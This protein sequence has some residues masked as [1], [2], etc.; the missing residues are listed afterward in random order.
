MNHRLSSCF[1]ITKYLLSL[2]YVRFGTIQFLNVFIL[3]LL[4]VQFFLFSKSN[5][6]AT[7]LGN[8]CLF[9]LSS[10]ILLFVKICL[11]VFP[12]M[13][14]MALGSDSASSRSIFLIQFVYLHKCYLFVNQNA[15]YLRGAPDDFPH[16]IVQCIPT[17]RFIY[18]H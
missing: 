9:G 6:V 1:C 18:F 3:T 14:G 16:T 7:C 8:C 15:K 12:V 17:L 4:C 5:W 10:L 2:F 13:F 11:S